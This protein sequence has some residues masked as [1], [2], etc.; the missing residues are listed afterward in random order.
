MPRD[1]SGDPSASGSSSLDAIP[2]VWRVL[3]IEDNDDTRRQLVQHFTESGWQV[4]SARTLRGALLI[5][6]R[7]VPHAIV[8]ELSLPDVRGYR[9][10]AD[11][12]RATPRDITIIAVTRVSSM[13]FDG[14]LKVG[15]DDVMAKPVDL[16]ELHRRLDASIEAKLAK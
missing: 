16:N 14:A 11:L 6:A 4:E 9:F 5:A 13:I 7:H 10:A 8:C 1:A 15:F 3:I 2:A 12:R